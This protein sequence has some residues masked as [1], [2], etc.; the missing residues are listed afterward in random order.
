MYRPDWTITSDEVVQGSILWL[1][2]VEEIEK[3]QLQRGSA[4][5]PVRNINNGSV[6]NGG[7]LNHPILVVSR[8][9]WDP[10]IIFFLPVSTPS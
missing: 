10:S 1:G 9:A 3:S 5:Q 6:A 8:P 2:S 7:M 4:L